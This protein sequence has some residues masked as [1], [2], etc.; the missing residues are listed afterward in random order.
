MTEN[1]SPAKD[2]EEEEFFLIPRSDYEEL[3]MDKEILDAL[4]FAGLDYD[5]YPDLMENYRGRA[6]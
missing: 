5:D 1:V 3:L 4:E 2:E 6:N